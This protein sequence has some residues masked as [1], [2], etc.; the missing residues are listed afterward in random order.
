MS[1]LSNPMS[2]QIAD[3]RQ[4]TDVVSPTGITD[5]ARMQEVGFDKRN[6]R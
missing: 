6:L 2:G 5:A 4:N 1:S 3:N